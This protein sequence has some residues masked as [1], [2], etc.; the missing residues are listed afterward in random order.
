MKSL[1]TYSATWI[2]VPLDLILCT[3]TLL[4]AYWLASKG[5]PI[6]LSKGIPELSG[7]LAALPGILGVFLATAL[8]FRLYRPRR[9]GSRGQSAEFGIGQVGMN[10]LVRGARRNPTCLGSARVHN[11]G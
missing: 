2:K 10:S 8:F 4:S 11:S 5:F 3:V 9:A 7:Y 6:K 1:R